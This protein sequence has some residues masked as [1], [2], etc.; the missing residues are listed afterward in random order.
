MLPVG[1]APIAPLPPPAPIVGEDTPPG[2]F[3][4]SAQA[5]LVLD[6]VTDPSLPADDAGRYVETS[7]AVRRR[8]LD[9]LVFTRLGALARVRTGLPTFG[10]D[11]R[12]DFDT[13]VGSP[14]PKAFL[15]GTVYGQQNA[16]TFDAAGGV[17]AGVWWQFEP[18][19]AVSVVPTLGVDLSTAS[20]VDVARYEDLARIDPDVFA[21]YDAP[22]P[23][24][25]FATFLGSY[26]ATMDS[27][28]RLRLGTHVAGFEGVDD[29]FVYPSIDVAPGRGLAPTFSLGYA[30]SYHFASASL[31]EP[32][33][34][35]RV[36]LSAFFWQWVRASHR[37]SAS[38]S[39]LV[40]QG[41]PFGDEV[42]V[43]LLFGLAYDFTAG[44]GV[45]DFS[46]LE[47][48]FRERFDETG[49]RV[50]RRTPR[51]SEPPP[52]PPAAP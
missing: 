48:T 29:V 2:P 23:V 1:G 26:R 14:V 22:R 28:V 13:P 36:D 33:V 25:L 5:T 12:I 21:R 3:T 18:L 49:G 42:D 38:A 6:K 47:M 15:E 30:L 50:I 8:F 27:I 32:Y 11:A 20:L 35:H 52:E 4:L 51:T 43:R 17:H 16:S 10:A 40:Q 9:G 31:S 39:A 19:P 7:L 46:P 44:R 45:S 41:S 24:E 37:V 34:R